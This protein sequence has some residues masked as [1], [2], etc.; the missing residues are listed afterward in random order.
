MAPTNA[1]PKNVPASRRKIAARR[2]RIAELER[3]P[4]VMAAVREGLE[5]ERL[6]QGVRF[7]D[8]KPKNG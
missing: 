1:K 7:E 8:L 5:S 6:G 2:R 4:A 3:D